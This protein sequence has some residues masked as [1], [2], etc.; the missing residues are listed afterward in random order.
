MTTKEYVLKYNLFKS[1]KFNHNEFVSDLTL[2]FITLLEVGKAKENIK[3]FNN[4]V[5]AIKMKFDAI[6]NKTAGNIE[7]IWNYF[8]ATVVV[9]FRENMF[10]EQM[11]KIRQ[12]RERKKQMYEERKKFEKEQFGFYDNMFFFSIISDLFK[13]KKPL[14]SFKILGLNENATMEDVK[15][16]YRKLSLEFHPDKGGNKEKFIEITEA[17]NKCLAFFSN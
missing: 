4:S 1:D 6:N 10:P 17:K 12:E 14:E 2:D 3:G 7:R 16:N 8:F 9:K 11:Q 15:A 13:I 5:N